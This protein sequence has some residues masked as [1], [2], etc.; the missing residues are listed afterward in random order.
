M[1]KERSSQHQ[2]EIGRDKE[3]RFIAEQYIS[4]GYPLHFHR[5]MEIYGVISGRV[6]I[7]IA[8]ERKTLEDGQFAIINSVESHSYEIENEAEVMYFHIGTCYMRNFLLLYP[9]KK[10]PHWLTDKEYNRKIYEFIKNE[11]IN[12]V[13]QLSELK[14]TSIAGYVIADIIEHYGIVERSGNIASDNNLIE[15]IVEYIYDHYNENITLQVLSEKFYI[16]PKALSKKFSNVIDVDFR[17]FVNDIRTQKAVEMLN[18]PKN[19][20]IPLNDIIGK[21]G[22]TNINTFYRSYNRNFS[23]HEI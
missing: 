3:N 23:S 15:Q 14:K 9:N 10:L 1:K 19:K 8:S 5:N 6:A 4:T 21:C 20:H 2:N 12:S 11:V 17:I 22:F 18:D 7:K 16:S 13:G